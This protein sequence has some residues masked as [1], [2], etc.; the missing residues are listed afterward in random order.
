MTCKAGG[1]VA[2]E[3]KHELLRLL[4]A[5]CAFGRVLNLEAKCRLFADGGTNRTRPHVLNHRRFGEDSV[6]CFRAV[7]WQ[8]GCAL[9]ALEET[10]REELPKA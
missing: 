9:N 6:G 7:G 10:S 4:D 5:A 1:V 3:S 2:I 8:S